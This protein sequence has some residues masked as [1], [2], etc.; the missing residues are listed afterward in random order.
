MLLGPTCHET[1]IIWHVIRLIYITELA[2]HSLRQSSICIG[3][4]RSA[5][6][7]SIYAHTVHTNN[8]HNN[9]FRL[10]TKQASLHFCRRRRM[11]EQWVMVNDQ[12]DC[13]LY[14]KSSNSFHS[15]QI[16]YM[17]HC[18]KWLQKLNLIK[19]TIAM[20]YAYQIQVMAAKIGYQLSSNC[21]SIRNRSSK[22]VC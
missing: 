11:L 4:S 19:T 13:K 16:S 9:L 21:R 5:N 8:S 10:K 20:L 17:W 12:M 2:V 1:I 15:S 6:T 14:T 22:L 7:I 3:N 18:N